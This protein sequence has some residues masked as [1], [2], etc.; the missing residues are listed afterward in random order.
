MLFCIRYF[1][2][3][4][5]ER[6]SQSASRKYSA[7]S[8]IPSLTNTLKR[9]RFFIFITPHRKMVIFATFYHNLAIYARGFYKPYKEHFP[10]N[11]CSR[12]IFAS[13]N[14]FRA[15]LVQRFFVSK[16]LLRICFLTTAFVWLIKITGIIRTPFLVSPL[17]Q[18]KVSL[19]KS[20]RHSLSYFFQT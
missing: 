16:I 9:A 13:K 17:L 3:P 8:R 7:S 5:V 15:S 20:F 19:Q 10:E 12:R 2:V 1:A 4:P 14:G 18:M 6:I 11:R